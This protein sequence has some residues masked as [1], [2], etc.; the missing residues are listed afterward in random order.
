MI[1]DELYSFNIYNL[2]SVGIPH[3][4]AEMYAVEYRH[5]AEIQSIVELNIFNILLETVCREV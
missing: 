2:M 3:S 1:S 5:R 4:C